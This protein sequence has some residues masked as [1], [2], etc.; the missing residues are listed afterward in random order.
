MKEA[1][2]AL[3]EGLH[4]RQQEKSILTQNAVALCYSDLVHRKE[5]MSCSRLKTMV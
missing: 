3:L 5:P 2:E 1:E 4:R